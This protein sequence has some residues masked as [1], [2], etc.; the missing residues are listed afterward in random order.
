MNMT[1]FGIDS[2]EFQGN[3]GYA[4]FLFSMTD[5]PFLFRDGEVRQ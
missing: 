5:S 4:D 2:T 3:T 1:S